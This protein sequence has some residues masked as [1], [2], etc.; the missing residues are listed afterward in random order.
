MLTNLKMIFFISG[1]AR[2]LDLIS[3]YY[4][5]VLQALKYQTQ[6]S[7]QW[8]ERNWK[9]KF[10]T[11]KQYIQNT[12]CYITSYMFS[13]KTHNRWQLI[14]I[15][16]MILLQCTSRRLLHRNINVWTSNILQKAI[17]TPRGFPW[18]FVRNPSDRRSE[19][20]I[21]AC[22]SIRFKELMHIKL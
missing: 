21:T 20:Q 16:W 19:W 6:I 5:M 4:M 12:K 7:V 22:M 17:S 15:I 11:S 10:S 18:I 14:Q 13:N 2:I 8:R 1:W 9:T 3:K